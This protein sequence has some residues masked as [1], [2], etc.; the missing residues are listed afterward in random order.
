MKRPWGEADALGSLLTNLD[1][2]QRLHDPY[3]TEATK[4]CDERLA[5]LK[6]ISPDAIRQL[7]ETLLS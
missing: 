6:M 5:Q 7:S 2:Y 1:T 4:L 3:A